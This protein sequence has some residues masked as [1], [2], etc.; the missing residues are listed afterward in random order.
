EDG[1]RD[2]HV[3]G[4]QTCALPISVRGQGLLA[5]G[6]GGADVFAEPVIV[7]LVD[8][9]DQDET[10]LGVVV[11]AGHDGVPD[12][13]GF[14]RF[15]DAAGNFAFVVHHVAFLYREVTVYELAGVGQVQAFVV[16]FFLGNREGQVPVVAVAHSFDE[17]FGDQQR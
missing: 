6:V 4:V 9:V 17:V 12:E 11:G 5:T 10:W 14:H 16:G 15:V 3:T 8:L 1:I 2:F 13:L 7:H